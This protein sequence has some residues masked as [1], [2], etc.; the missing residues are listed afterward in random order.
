[1]SSLQNEVEQTVVE[2]P[3]LRIAWFWPVLGLAF[4][5][6][7]PYY[8]SLETFF[9]HDDFAIIWFHKDCPLWQPWLFFSPKVLTAD[10]RPLQSY[11]F[12][13][14]WQVFGAT[15]FPFCLTMLVFHLTNIV[16]FGRLVNRMFKDLALTLLSVIFFSANWEYCDVIFWKGNCA[17]MLSWMFTLGAANFFVE[18]LRERTRKRYLWTIAL[19]VGALLS[20]EGAINVPPLLAL[21]YMAMP[22]GLPGAADLTWRNVR[23]W[24]RMFAD[25]VRLLAPFFLL[26]VAYV[27]LHRLLI[28]DMYDWLPKGY[29]LINPFESTEAFFSPLSATIDSMGFW[30]TSP[31][32]AGASAL[33]SM[34]LRSDLIIWIWKRQWVFPYL[35]LLATLALR[36]RRMAFGLGWAVLAFFPANLL[37]DGNYHTAR[38]FYGP[39]MGVSIILAELFVVADRA[40]AKRGRMREIAPARL[41]GSILILVFVF[42]NVFCTTSIVADDARKCSEIEDL[43]LELARRRSRIKPMSLFEVHCM[44]QADHFH[45]GMGLREMFKLALQDDTVE[46]ILPDQRSLSKSALERL[47]RDYPRPTEIFRRSDGTY[48]FVPPP[49]GDGRTD[50]PIPTTN[51]EQ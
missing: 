10:Y 12:G 46:A 42:T 43:Y 6:S 15:V 19:F 33:A 31:L 49:T 11:I 14:F 9:S 45:E 29:N 40:I 23:Y 27:G 7:F 48:R 25:G 18:F 44:N 39:L 32:T 34:K 51:N 38:Y 2:Q 36:S 35:V 13:F 24:G 50:D 1:M 17:T 28:Q 30:L 16:L 20:K 21:V 3:E 8:F 4:C 26:T 37:T 5:L 41:V 22:V 47:L